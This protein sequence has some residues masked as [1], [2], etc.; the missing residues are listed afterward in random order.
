MCVSFTKWFYMQCVRLEDE[1]NYRVGQ[2]EPNGMG[3][4]LYWD[5][6]MREGGW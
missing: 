6:D 2:K 1:Q 5:V 3:P 4:C